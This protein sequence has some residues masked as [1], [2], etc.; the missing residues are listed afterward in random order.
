MHAFRG[1]LFL[2]IRE[3]G[4]LFIQIGCVYC[5]EFANSLIFLVSLV[6]CLFAIYVSPYFQFSYSKENIY[7]FYF[8][9][10]SFC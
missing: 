5:T 1:S 4:R 9:I 3:M 10:Y 2:V 6:E 7:V 8:Y